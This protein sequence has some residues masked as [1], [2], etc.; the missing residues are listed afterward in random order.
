[1]A[2]GRLRRVAKGENQEA[3]YGKIITLLVRD[4]G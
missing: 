3:S 2:L 4:R 1:M